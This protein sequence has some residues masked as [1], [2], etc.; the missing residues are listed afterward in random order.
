MAKA[1][2]QIGT[3]FYL[4]PEICAEKPYD[5]KSDIWALGVRGETQAFYSG[6]GSASQAAR[7]NS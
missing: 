7:A 5:A 6:I 3:P 2:T 1:M 4:S